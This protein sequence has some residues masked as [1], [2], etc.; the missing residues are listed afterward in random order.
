MAQGLTVVF[1]CNIYVTAAQAI[2]YSGSLADLEHIAP[3]L[4]L[5]RRKRAES[6]L[7]SLKGG[8]GPVKFHVGSEEV[9]LP[10]VGFPGDAYRG[11]IEAGASARI[12]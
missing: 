7:W 10:S 4:P 5:Y 3:T 8:A 1:D 9:N 12:G 6:L 2:G 11:V